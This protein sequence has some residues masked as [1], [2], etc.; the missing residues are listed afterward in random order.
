VKVIVLGA[1]VIGVSTAYFLARDGHQ[2][3]VIDR[4]PA[5]GLETSFA[6]GGQVSA[7]H[8]QPWSN[9][10]TLLKLASWLGRKDA[11]LY[12][13]FSW[14]PAM[15]GFFLR[16][17]SACRTGPS[18][19]NGLKALKLALYSR[20][21]LAQLRTETG[22]QFDAVDRGILHVYRTNRDLDR[23]AAVADRF[24]ALGL[25]TETLNREA[26]IAMEPALGSTQEN[27]AGAIYSPGDL[28][29]DAHA[30]TQAL[31]GLAADA[32]VEFRMDT[33]I[34]RLAQ[35]GGRITGVLT[36]YSMVTAD[37]YVCALGSY[38][39]PLLAGIGIRLPIYPTK[40]YSVTVPVTASNRAPHIS[41]TDDDAKIV[42]SR[43]GDKLRIAGTAEF[44]GF[45]TLINAPRA[46]AVLDA[47]LRL[48]PGAMDAEGAEFWAGLRPLTP[49]GIPVIGGTKLSNLYLNT[50]H[51]T[52]GW[53]MGPGSGKA[54]AEMISG[55]SPAVDLSPYDAERF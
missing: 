4:Q 46:R 43:L 38:S 29:G 28:S 52:Q 53:T 32:G 11:P 25:A 41:I 47:G 22:I 18:N 17:L 14:D 13:R 36:Q 3:T 35:M 40:G 12:F 33:K 16:F 48:F 7:S 8:A 24:R 45:N 34:L 10:A 2:V 6:N 20:D 27:L 15:W 31:A 39:E 44:T 23:A 26:S 54:L 49:D 37:A 5:A 51:G 42:V 55:N 1:G 30:F 50:G 9:P 21:T 19:A